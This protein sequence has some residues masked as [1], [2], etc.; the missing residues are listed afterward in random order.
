MQ[1]VSKKDRMG[2][3]AGHGNHNPVCQTCKRSK[4][5]RGNGICDCV[6]PDWK[7]LN[8]QN[9]NN[10]PTVKPLS[11]MR[12][13]CRLITPPGGLILDPFGGSGTTGLAAIQEGFHC[14][15]I[16]Q[17]AEYCEIARKRISAL[18]RR[19]ESFA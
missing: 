9:K 14:I 2:G 12:Y 8:Q 4:F 18:P 19:L 16:E 15:L 7:V 1:E 11:L 10:H 3:S 13:L 5:D 6:N 17:Q